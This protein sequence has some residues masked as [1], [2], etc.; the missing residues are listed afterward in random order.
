MFPL[1]GP[2][3]CFCSLCLLPRLAMCTFV[4]F[5]C[6]MC[7][8][9]HCACVPAP[10][11]T[12]WCVSLSTCVLFSFFVFKPLCF[13]YS[14]SVSVCGY[15]LF[16]FGVMLSHG[17]LP[18]CTCLRVSTDSPLCFKVCLRVVHLGPAL[19]QQCY[20]TAHTDIISINNLIPL[21]CSA[22]LLQQNILQFCQSFSCAHLR[23]LVLFRL[24]VQFAPGM[25]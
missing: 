21:Q 24:T 3:L 8:V 25:K 19:V 20:T 4:Y 18:V 7:L 11:I 6:S 10:C 12:A 13:I 2:V 14:W 17:T 22:L 16:M 15:T 23:H 1:F 9:F 5:L